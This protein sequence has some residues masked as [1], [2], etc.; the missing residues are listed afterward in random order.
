MSARFRSGMRASGPKRIDSGNGPETFSIRRSRQYSSFLGT[1]GVVPI[2]FPHV[3]VATPN[4]FPE[5][6]EAVGKEGTHLVDALR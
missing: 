4:L 5:L 2:R 6:F 3:G 1:A